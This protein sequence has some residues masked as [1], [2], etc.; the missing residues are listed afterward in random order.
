[1]T[2]AC[3]CC[4]YLTLS[5]P[6]TGTY[7]ICPV[8][9][10]E[11]D[12]AQSR[13]PSLVA[14]ANGTNLIDA[15]AN[16]AVFGAVEAQFAEFTRAPL[17]SE[18]ASDDD[19]LQG[20]EGGPG[21]RDGGGGGHLGLHDGGQDAATL[22]T[23]YG[24][25]G[26]T[27][28]FPDGSVDFATT[29]L[30]GPDQM[31]CVRIDV[32][33][34]PP[35]ALAVDLAHERVRSENAPGTSVRTSEDYLVPRE[36]L[37]TPLHVMPFSRTDP[38]GRHLRG[39]DVTGSHGGTAVYARGEVLET[40]TGDVGDLLL[41]VLTS[42]ELDPD[43]RPPG[44]AGS[45]VA[46]PVAGTRQGF[47][48]VTVVVP[49]GWRMRTLSTFRT[50]AGAQTWGFET[51]PTD[52]QTTSSSFADWV[53]ARTSVAR[54]DFAETAPRVPFPLAGLPDAVLLRSMSTD[55]DGDRYVTIDLVAAAGGLGLRASVD[56]RQADLDE[57][58]DEAI[59][60]LASCEFA[61]VATGVQF[62]L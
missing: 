46:A 2:F 35:D 42:I 38:D 3:P 43:R 37:P 33:G 39:I 54:P 1:M 36:T 41:P 5:A 62:I 23:L 59:A 12:A 53:V 45:P 52:P 18:I 58:V 57:E 17:A 60:C 50:A 49:N 27:M 30:A 20:G 26:V 55:P 4:G 29:M 15:R 40:D 34:C 44:A 61:L 32:I 11:D 22:R 14:G 16:F 13:D 25:S 31:V 28:M 56:I 21:G 10:W 19:G 7:E 48:G 6:A 9:F 24:V 51:W 8:C 47:L